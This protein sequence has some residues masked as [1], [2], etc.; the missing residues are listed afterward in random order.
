[1]VLPITSASG[2]A[3]MCV[4]IYQG[5]SELVSLDLHTGIDPRVVPVRNEKGEIIMDKTNID[6][7][8]KYMPCGPTCH[9]N[10]KVIPCQTFISE[11]GGITSSILTKILSTLDRLDVFP[12]NN[13][14]KPLLIVDGH[15]S[16]LH[17]NF[18]EHVVNEEHRWHVCLGVPYATSYWQVGDSQEQN[19]TFKVNW[20]RAKRKYM[21]WKNDRGMGYKMSAKEILPLLNDIW[22]A[23]YDNIENN[24]K[25]TSKRGWNPPSRKLLTHPEL[26]D[27]TESENKTCVSSNSTS[28]LFDVSMI[29]MEDGP[30]VWIID[31]ICQERARKGGI[32]S[33]QQKLANGQEFIKAMQECKRVTAGFLVSFGQHELDKN[34]A[35][36]VKEKF[37][38]N[39]TKIK[40][41]ALKKKL[42]IKKRCLAINNIR[43]TKGR[44]D[45]NGFVGWT[46]REMETYI[47][48]KKKKGDPKM[49]KGLADI[50]QRCLNCMK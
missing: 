21:S 4:I 38:T 16:R 36:M 2:R 48:Y 8:G 50:R 12:R 45:V 13:G 3:V 30:A 41:A 24:L 32:E 34:V 5:K 26:I 43:T 15:E 39:Q 49:P 46:K 40:N 25:A 27:D 31:K 35:D 10:G 11:S 42:E 18:L 29:Q 47:Q 7:Y 23:R 1:M 20:Y 33:R 17:H 14:V 6:G 37:D 44:E 28:E 9:Y 22:C 19:G